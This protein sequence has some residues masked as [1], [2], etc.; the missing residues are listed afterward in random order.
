[1]KYIKTHTGLLIH[2]E[3]TR[4]VRLHETPAA[5]CHT[6]RECYSKTTGRR[7][8]SP[9]SLSRLILSSIQPIE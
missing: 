4:R 9:E 6:H 1:M 3:Q 5:W 2:K 7:C 8:G